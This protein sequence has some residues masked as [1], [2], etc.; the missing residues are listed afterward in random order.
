MSN[1]ARN[2]AATAAV[3]SGVGL[4]GMVMTGSG[5]P[6]SDNNASQ[7]TSA[8]TYKWENNWDKREN[9]VQN[10]Q[11]HARTIYLL[12]PCTQARPVPQGPLAHTEDGNREVDQALEF[13]RR[14]PFTKIIYSNDELAINT[15]RLF[16][17]RWFRDLQPGP[18]IGKSDCI[19][20]VYP[21]TPDPNLRDL[22]YPD[23]M[24]F[25]YE[26]KVEAAFRM[27]FHRADAAQLNETRELYICSP[28]LIR[29]LLLRALQMNQN[30]WSRWNVAPCSITEIVVRAN[31]YI[32][33]F[34]VGEKTRRKATVRQLQGLRF[35]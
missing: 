34:S 12:Q 4:L 27:I 16:Y 19:Q 11:N 28:N 8:P 35:D 15:W 29:C 32:T 7:H 6:L 26:M 31:G 33:V 22:V 18:N 17:Q 21:C 10:S 9:E 3:A 25:G 13:L 23:H 2:V 14:E 20:E 1:L 24:I 5:V 30:Q